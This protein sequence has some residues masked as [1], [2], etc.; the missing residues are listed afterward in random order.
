MEPLTYGAIFFATRSSAAF[1]V[2]STSY[3][4]F[5]DTVVL[6]AR[7]EEADT[8]DGRRGSSKDRADATP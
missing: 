2:A 3:R 4:P 7:N 1:T 8:I 6:L 5:G